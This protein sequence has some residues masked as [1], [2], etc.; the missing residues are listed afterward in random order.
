MIQL[1]FQHLL[2]DIEQQ[3]YAL[4][5][6]RVGNN[7]ELKD[8][9]QFDETEHLSDIAMRYCEEGCALLNTIL[10]DKLVPDNSSVAQPQTDELTYDNKTWGF[11]TTIASPDEHTLATLFHRFVVA[12]TLWQWAKL[13]SPEEAN[14]LKSQMLDVQK[15]IENIAYSISTPTKHRPCTCADPEAPH[16]CQPEITIEP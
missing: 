13:Y 10:K 6:A 2:Y 12:Y 14:A 7:P 9:Q 3:T 5:T 8:E 1:Q 16:C 15:E 4:A 11:N